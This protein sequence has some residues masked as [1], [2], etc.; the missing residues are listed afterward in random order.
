MGTKNSSSCFVNYIAIAFLPTLFSL[1]IVLGYIG[2]LQFKV[3]LYSLIIITLIYMIF[4]L[5]IKHNA[6]YVICNMRR[7]SVALQKALQKTIYDNSLTIG[8]KT[9]STINIEDFINEYYKS[10]RNENFA[11]VA[12]SLFPMLGILGTFTAIAVSMPDFSISDTDTLD[13]QI[14]ILLSGIGT[15]FYASIFGIFLSIVWIYFEKRGLSK[16]DSD[17][18]YLESLYKEYIWSESE[19]RK[20]EHMQYNLRDER[21]VSL[22]KETFSLEFIE[23]LNDRHLENFK[24]VMEE[25]NKNFTNVATH[26]KIVL[27]EL[28]ETVSAVNT[29]QN[30]LEANDRIEKNIKKFI[31]V[32]DKLQDTL[33]KFNNIRYRL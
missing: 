28:K 8:D 19:L 30:A 23:K 2:I 9:K 16:F 6:N 33:D 31:G 26:L 18:L 27:Q 12:S 22:L 11:T 13:K 15:A 4:L 3:E 17:K 5:F 1:G 24:I 29:T 7:E 10:F 32:T 14:S 25:T 20:H 21:L